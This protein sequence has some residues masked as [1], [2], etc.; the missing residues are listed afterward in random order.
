MNNMRHGKG[1]LKRTNGYKFVGDWECNYRQG[2]GIEYLPD[3]GRI[4]GTWEKD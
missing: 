2:S 4:E 3:G 1:E